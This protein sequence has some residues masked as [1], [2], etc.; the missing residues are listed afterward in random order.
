MSQFPDDDPP[1]TADARP[2]AAPRNP[3]LIAW[4]RK[5]LV[6][7]G[8]VVGVVAAALFAARR[9]PVYQSSAQVLVV[10]KFADAAIPVA[11]G[12][13]RLNFYE[14]Y[15]STHLALIKSRVVVDRAVKKRDLASLPSFAGVANPAAAVTAGLTVARDTKESGANNIINLSYKGPAAD[16]CRVVIEAV[17]ESYKDFLDETYRNVSDDTVGLITQARDLL[18]KDL[19][20]KERK[21]A[22]FRDKVPVAP[23][24]SRDGPPASQ[25]RLGELDNRRLNLLMR[26]AELEERLQALDRAKKEGN[27][28]E[29]VEALTAAPAEKAAAPDATLEQQLLPLILKE[30]SLLKDFGADHPD[31]L[32]VRQAIATTR[33]FLSPAKRAAR[34]AAGRPAAEGDPVEA[35]ARQMRQELAGVRLARQ[36]LVALTADEQKEARELARYDIQDASYRADIARTQQIYD[37]TIS[38]LK[39]I[40]LVRDFGGYDAKVISPAGEGGRVGTGFVQFLL[41]GVALGLLLGVGL[42][43]LA[44]M[45]DRSFR[46]PDEIRR[47]LGLPVVAHVPIFEAEGTPSGPDGVLLD[48]SLAIYHRPKSGEAEAYRSLRTALYFTTRGEVNKVIQV[49]S[50]NKGDGKSTIAA[51]LA[52][53]IAQ[54]GKRVVLL[55]GDMRRPRVHELFGV[56]AE[57]GLGSVIAGTAQLSAA[58]LDSGI[59]RLSLLTCGPRPDNPSELLTQPRFEEVLRELRGQFDFVIV[60]T[61]P[62]LAVTDPAVVVSRMDA[63]FLAVRL[64]RNGRPAA[65]RAREIL[66]TLRANVLGVVV[67][68]VGKETGGYG[69]E[70]Y[71]YEYGYGGAYAV[72]TAEGNG[73]AGNGTPVATGARPRGGRRGRSAGWLRRWFR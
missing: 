50:P 53:A 16:D 44:D 31:V 41:A 14:D 7:L 43:Y 51:N 9:P 62:L 65:E 58:L 12:D 40:N 1:E 35:Y 59:D 61:P 18:Q 63:V 8:L 52:I 39:E 72:A 36:S 6:A 11:G 55:D 71:T 15:V 57:V 64:S 32:A 37:Q 60:D 33:E 46:G 56:T 34:M 13:P 69:Y 48:R 5:P 38:R 54:S 66:Q 24:Q 30:Q 42:A 68:G 17:I 3:L 20:E 70:H 49:T 10:K 29:L 28:R 21:Y 22:E 2:T 73:H 25:V 27:A 47:R 67:N 4:Q 26:A 45:T 23:A 19:A